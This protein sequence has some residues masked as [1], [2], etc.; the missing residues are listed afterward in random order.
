MLNGS[1]PV[2]ERR[3]DDIRDQHCV[4]LRSQLWAA[5]GFE[6]GVF[7]P[8]TSG[9][10]ASM[11]LRVVGL[12]HVA[13]CGACCTCRIMLTGIFIFAQGRAQPEPR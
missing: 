6:V 8:E 1:D 3:S 12:G 10:D 2:R 9:T 13:A 5:N 11:L 4:R 7:R